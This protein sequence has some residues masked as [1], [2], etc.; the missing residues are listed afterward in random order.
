[1]CSLF[2]HFSFFWRKYFI[3]NISKKKENVLKRNQNILEFVF[4][5]KKLFEI[6]FDG[7]NLLFRTIFQNF[8]KVF[9]LY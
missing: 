6:R 3:E 2:L 8:F 1:M 9:E 4:L 5:E 7:G